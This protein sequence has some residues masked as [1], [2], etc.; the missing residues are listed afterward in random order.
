MDIYKNLKLFFIIF[1][2]LIQYQASS[3]NF[4]SIGPTISAGSKSFPI[5]GRLGVGGSLEFVHGITTHG[6]VRVYLGYDYFKHKYPK[7]AS[8]DSLV[9]LE[10]MG[11]GTNT[12]LP[13]R[14]GY[15]YFLFRD[16]TFF[17]GE[18]GVSVLHRPTYNSRYDLTKNLFTYAVGFGQRF[19]IEESRAIELSLY[20]NYNRLY[21]DFNLNYYTFRVAYGCNFGRGKSRVSIK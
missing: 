7:G 8:H 10:A 19:K 16:A 15:Q 6:G 13:I 2:I 21:K 4:I 20:Y 1:L 3:Q 17:Y 9:G 14:V 18:A 11:W 5:N 12:F